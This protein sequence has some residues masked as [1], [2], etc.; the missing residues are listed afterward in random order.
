MANRRKDEGFL[1]NSVKR[2]KIASCRAKGEVKASLISRQ[3]RLVE[4]GEM[5]A[6]KSLKIEI[7]FEYSPIWL[8]AFSQLEVE[9]VHLP[10]CLSFSHLR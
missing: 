1:D 7:W 3:K 4:H 5:K 8:L 9:I 6:V 2:T 10:Q